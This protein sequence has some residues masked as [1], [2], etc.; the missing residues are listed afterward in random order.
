MAKWMEITSMPNWIDSAISNEDDFQYALFQFYRLLTSMMNRY[1]ID[2]ESCTKLQLLN[3][4]ALRFSLFTPTSIVVILY[5]WRWNA[6][7]YSSVH[8]IGANHVLCCPHLVYWIKSRLHIFSPQWL[9]F[10]YELL[11]WDISISLTFLGASL[12]TRFNSHMNANC[13]I[14]IGG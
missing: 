9:L 8:E 11:K 3:W 2:A 10:R 6:I 4:I 7:I 5:Q 1:G 13:I 12:A 14:F